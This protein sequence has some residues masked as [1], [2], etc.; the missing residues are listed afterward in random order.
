[1]NKARIGILSS[2]PPNIFSSL[3][4]NEKFTALEQKKAL[5]SEID[6][7]KE[8][9]ELE[10][11][12]ENTIFEVVNV[13]QWL[14]KN[15]QYDAYI[16]WWSP[17]MVT[18]RA[19]WM[20]ALEQFIHQE[21][22]AWKHAIWFCFWHQILA[23]AFGW[24][25]TNASTRKIWKW[26]VF[27]NTAGQGDKIFSQMN[28]V[29]ESLWSHKQYVSNIWEAEELWWNEHS[30][31]QIIRIGDNAW[32]CQFHSEFTPYFCSFLVKLMSES[33]EK[34]QLDIHMILNELYNMKW[35]E[36]S[37]VIT[38]FLKNVLATK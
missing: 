14:P 35:N 18:E 9:L 38:F 5:M 26:S 10:Y 36:S 32:W 11:V 8:S 22:N 1:M 12:K 6:V 24:Q 33:L 28:D 23:S 17:S 19:E 30:S 29:F 37:Q 31:N 20:I 16:L 2:V 7:W 34:E 21:I 3:A 25:V 13:L 27:L 15:W 4:Q